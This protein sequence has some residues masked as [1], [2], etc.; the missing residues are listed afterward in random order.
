M[1]FS[2]SLGYFVGFFVLGGGF[3]IQFVIDDLTPVYN[4]RLLQKALKMKESL[5]HR[6][7]HLDKNAITGREGK[8][9]SF[10]L[11]SPGENWYHSSK[12]RVRTCNDLLHQK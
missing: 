5:A 10:N 1:G 11:S 8:K 4:L 12:G 7:T 6:A 3:L 9:S 2:C